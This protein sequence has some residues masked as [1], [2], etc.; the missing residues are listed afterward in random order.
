MRVT[1]LRQFDHWTVHYRSLRVNPIH[2]VNK[3]PLSVT[4]IAILFLVAGIVGLAYHA[5]EFKT[6][7]P[8]QYDVLWV[9]LVRLLAIICAVFMLRGANWSRWVLL[10][11]IAYHVVLS[12]FHSLSQ[13]IVHGLLL[14]VIAYFLLDRSA[15]A[16]FCGV[17]GARGDNTGP[18]RL[19]VGDTADCQSALQTKDK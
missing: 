12:G 1:Q 18:R 4:I 16:Y 7:G 19:P 2:I 10:V 11:W 3:R 13:V 6:H 17:K 15:S 9:C 5:R 14:A 8:F